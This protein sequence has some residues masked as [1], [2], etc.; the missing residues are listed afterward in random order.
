MHRFRSN[1]SRRDQ[2]IQSTNDLIHA[3]FNPGRKS[4]SR[5]RADSTTSEQQKEKKDKKWYQ[6]RPSFNFITIHYMYIMSCTIL[7]SVIIYGSQNMP[8]IDALFFAA[9]AST[10]SGLNTIDLN[11][12]YLYQQVVLMLW[13]CITTP[14][15]INTSVVVIRLYWF[16]KRFKHL[17]ERA[18]ENQR[19]W[20]KSRTKSEAKVE[21]DPVNLEKG[22]AGRDITVLHHTTKPN[23]MSDHP[24]YG[25]AGDHEVKEMD[26]K[27][28]ST[29]SNSTDAQHND[30]TDGSQT[31]TAG[32]TIESHTQVEDAP[33][34]PLHTRAITFPDNLP[35]PHHDATP[36]SEPLDISQHIAI[37]KRQQEA[38][39][40]REGTLRIPGPRDFDR[41]EVPEEIQAVPAVRRRGT[42]DSNEEADHITRM[43]TQN[44]EQG[45]FNADD[46]PV[47]RGITI[48]EPAE[49]PKRTQTTGTAD[50]PVEDV[51]SPFRNGLRRIITPLL[52]HHHRASSDHDSRSFFARTGT[53]R[54]GTFGS[55]NNTDAG[56]LS[57]AATIGRNSAFIGLSEE[58][59]E[60]LGGIEYRS[61]KLLLKIL[62]CYYVGFHTLALL[63]YLPWIEY[64][65]PWKG[66][67]ESDGIT[68]GWWAVF[69]AASMFNDLGF[70]L[71]PDSMISFQMAV[72]ILLIGSFLII[73]GN[74][75]FPVMLRFV[76]W[77]MSK[78]VIPDSPVWQELRFLLDHPRRCFT[79]LFPS[80][81]NWILF[82]ILAILNILD[83]IFFIVLNIGD[84][85]VGDM[86]AGIQ[87]LNGWFQAAS[88]RTAGFSSVNIATLAPGIQVSYM[89][90]MYISV[91]P[92]ALSV[93]NTNVYEEASLGF[94]AQENETDMNDKGFIA[95]HLRRQLSFDLWYVFGGFFII[96]IIEGQR[97]SAMSDPAFSLFAVLFEIVSAYGTV[98]LSLGYPTVNASFSSQ[99]HTGSK[100]II[101]AMMIRGRHR[102]LPY[103]L[104]RA[105]LLPSEE[106]FMRESEE[107]AKRYGRRSSVNEGPP[108]RQT[109]NGLDDDGNDVLDDAEPG[110]PINRQD[111]RLS[112]RASNASGFSNMTSNR[113]TRR[114]PGRHLAKLLVGGLGAGPTISKYD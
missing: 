83:L 65:Q 104:D 103:A 75:G 33:A 16:Q 58:Q 22:V 21:Q 11:Q 68:P 107:A 74:T 105:V 50:V 42:A 18:R 76:I 94:Y 10:Q 67:V 1:N 98:G 2:T 20:A 73:I 88:T 81:A 7:G 49:R 14:I 59:R 57:Y 44:S 70:T 69:T 36:A 24:K 3:A 4:R 99:L 92:I 66:I 31:L 84:P 55:R 27:A 15:F 77:C 61:L 63:V 89:I 48:N 85:I 17:V 80:R 40:A 109:W 29:N 100:L 87:V 8:Y 35:A 110:A 53:G 102:G 54:S 60:E 39:K 26:A 28:A 113:R 41:G 43:L 114:H 64:T 38:A 23:G 34:P 71:T 45:R 25:P 47:R 79:L 46:H 5:S 95:Q 12:L 62:I 101:A 56:Y 111:T 32:N 97:L 19:T 106:R 9:G 6:H 90:M 112:R 72:L 78:C 52:P 51:A 93:R 13:A 82:G 96:A 91:L 30:S 108:R 37:V 86:P